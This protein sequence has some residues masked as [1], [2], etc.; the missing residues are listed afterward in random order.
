MRNEKQVEASTTK[1]RGL[2]YQQIAAVFDQLPE[3]FKATELYE[4]AKM[5]ST[6]S[7]QRRMLIASVLV[8]DFKCMQMNSPGGRGRHWKKPGA[9][10]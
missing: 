8:H 10:T 6:H 3:R 2:V 7:M 4:L 1:N 9:V 5:P